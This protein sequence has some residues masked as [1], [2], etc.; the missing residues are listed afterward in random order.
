[1]EKISEIEDEKELQRLN[2]TIFSKIE[3]K[4]NQSPR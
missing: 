3:V 1:M 4:N 2:D